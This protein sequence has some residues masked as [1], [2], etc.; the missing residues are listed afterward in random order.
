[1]R[2]PAIRGLR[3][4]GLRSGPVPRLLLPLC[5][6][7]VLFLLGCYQAHLLEGALCVTDD[8]CGISAVLCADARCVAE[9]CTFVPT[10][11]GCAPGLTCDPIRGC[12]GGIDAPSADAS[13]EVGLD[14]GPD[15]DAPPSTDVPFD[16]I[17]PDGG[18]DTGLDAP[19]RDAPLDVRFDVGFDAG[20]DV[21]PLDVGPLEV[22]PLDAGFDAARDAGFDAGRDAGP[23]DVNVLDV[24]RDGGLETGRDGGLDAGR[25]PTSMARRCSTSTVITVPDRP[26][27]STEVM[28]LELW[29]LVR[30]PGV[31]ARKGDVGNR[32]HLEIVVEGRGAATVLRTGWGTGTLS[33][34]VSVPFAEHLGVYT[35]IAISVRP[36]ADGRHELDLWV[37][38]VRVG[39]AI[40]PAPVFLAFNNTP[41]LLCSFD[42]DLDEVRFWGAALEAEV[43]DAR[44]FGPVS[45]ST[46]GLLAY[47]PIEGT[48]QIIFDRTLRGSDGVAGDF[49]TPDPRD[50]AGIPGGAF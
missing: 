5:V 29:A 41:L 40:L 2:L 11:D 14:G 46:G 6:L 32:R 37:N 38:A 45:P 50:P 44:R 48:G 47:W 8:D 28:T 18:R 10:P 13:L 12:I 39:A 1:M 20:R 16:T 30:G 17:W 34:S 36:S 15:A 9:R 22:G 7:P 49:S 26:V 35:H 4:F 31:I 23:F 21:G 42:G 25:P 43:L 33:Q 24:G 3:R 27:L 19:L